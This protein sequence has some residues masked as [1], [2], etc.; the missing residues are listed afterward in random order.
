MSTIKKNK[1]VKKNVSISGTEKN[2]NPEILLELWEYRTYWGGN[3]ERIAVRQKH[4]AAI[5]KVKLK[6][7]KIF[8]GGIE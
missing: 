8:I 2:N 4:V 3:T 7:N 5:S 6:V 1:I